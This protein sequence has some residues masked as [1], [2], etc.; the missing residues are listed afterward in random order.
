MRSIKTQIISF[1]RNMNVTFIVNIKEIFND[2]KP[3]PRSIKHFSISP[4][5]VQKFGE[6]DFRVKT[7]SYPL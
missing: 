7:R 4:S 6:E 1:S 2:E 5:H 3:G